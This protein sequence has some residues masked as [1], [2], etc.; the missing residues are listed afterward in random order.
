LGKYIDDAMKSTRILSLLA[1]LATLSLAYGFDLAWEALGKIHAS[2]LNPA[3]T[4]WLNVLIELAFSTTMVFLVWLILVRSRKDTLVSW[5]SAILGLLVLWLVTPYGLYLRA[6]LPR[7][8]LLYRFTLGLMGFGFVFQTGAF[9]TV[10]GVASL[11]RRP[12]R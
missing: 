8:S 4:L 9:L 3:A 11:L 7:I 12:H 1:I 2:T 6:F 5:S 10:L